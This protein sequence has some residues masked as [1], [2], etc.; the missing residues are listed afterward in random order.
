MSTVFETMKRPLM[1]AALVLVLGA[2]VASAV[3]YC[4]PCAAPPPVVQPRPVAYTPPVSPCGMNPCGSVAPVASSSYVSG[5]SYGST[6]YEVVP[7]V[8]QSSTS[9]YVTNRPIMYAGEEVPY[10][11][12]L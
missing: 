3:D 4:S 12:G 6:S 8:T 2:G 1:A 7:S 10:V 11:P 5:Y 9:S